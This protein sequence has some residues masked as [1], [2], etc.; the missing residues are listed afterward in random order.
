MSECARCQRPVGD[1]LVCTLC[2]NDAAKALGNIPALEEQLDIAITRQSR[3]SAL[4]DGSRSA[5]TPV[6][7]HVKAGE[8]RDVLRNIL[9][10]WTRLYSEEARSDLPVDTL[11]AMSLFLLRR[12]EWFRHHLIA[13][14][15]VDEVT[16]AVRTV[17]RVIDSPPNRTTFAVGPCPD[18]PCPGEVRA[19]IPSSEDQRPR[20]ECNVCHAVWYGESW[21]R[22]GRRIND[23][24]D[25]VARMLDIGR[26]A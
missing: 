12:V 8:A 23:R 10:G 11:A 4:T 1:A 26:G 22:T 18:E 20:L 2:G 24:R 19:Y 9:V 3:F 25:A 5:E 21:L 14:E 13:A 16:E 17:V 7:F 15:F 6:P